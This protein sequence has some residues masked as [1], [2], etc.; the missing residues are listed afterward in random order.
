[1]RDLIGDLLDLARIETG[2]L[3]VAPESAE[4]A[5][6]VDRARSTFQSGGGRDNLSIDLGTDL[7]R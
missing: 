7:P 6:L 4:V 5:V 3:P 1:M 2:T